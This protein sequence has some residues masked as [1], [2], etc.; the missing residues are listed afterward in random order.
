[1]LE[2]AFRGQQLQDLLQLQAT[3]QE[4]DV[5]ALQKVCTSLLS[6]NDPA[7]VG[8]VPPAMQAAAAATRVADTLQTK[9]NECLA[10]LSTLSSQIERHAETS[11]AVAVELRRQPAC[12]ELAI[13]REFVAGIQSE[14]AHRAGHIARLRGH[15]TLPPFSH[16]FEALK[17]EAATKLHM[18][19]QQHSGQQH[20][21]Q[22]QLAQQELAVPQGRGT[23]GTSPEL[24]DQVQVLTRGLHAVAAQVEQLVRR[25]PVPGALQ[26]PQIQAAAA[27]AAPGPTNTAAEQPPGDVL[28]PRAAPRIEEVSPGGTAQPGLIQTVAKKR[29]QEERQ[30][31]KEV[32]V[33]PAASKAP[34]GAAGATESRALR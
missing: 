33:A 31:D 18:I 3:Q 10:A 24:R 21:Q 34:K 12:Q 7:F 14:V 16:V 5:S 4:C 11:G 32:L 27:A 17:A 23:A 2:A 28:I 26:L 9:I 25:Q 13:E 30:Q 22:P 15:C 1:M 19:A 8:L 20:Q 29:Q 6:S